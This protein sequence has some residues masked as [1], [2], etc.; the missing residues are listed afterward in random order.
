MLYLLREIFFWGIAAKD[1]WNKIGKRTTINDCH[2]A[3]EI[4]NI[5]IRTK[6]KQFILFVATASTCV[7]LYTSHISRQYRKVML[8]HFSKRAAKPRTVSGKDTNIKH[9]ASS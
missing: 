9:F 3:C 7:Q 8:Q 4:A 1:V 5:S 2:F 6:T